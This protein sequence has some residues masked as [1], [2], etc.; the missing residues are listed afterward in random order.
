MFK[1]KAQKGRIPYKS[2][3]KGRLNSKINTISIKLTKG[4]R[5]SSSI[6]N[7][8]ISILQKNN[9]NINKSLSQSTTLKELVGNNKNHM[10]LSNLYA[11]KSDE[12]VY[13]KNT[14]NKNL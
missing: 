9:I 6:Y 2:Y 12:S 7:T 14:E 8:I 3:R 1:Y 4:T 5:I 11:N 13:N 10:L